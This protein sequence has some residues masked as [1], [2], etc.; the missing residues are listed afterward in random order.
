MRWPFALVSVWLAAGQAMAAEAARDM[1]AYLADGYRIAEKQ[2]EKRTVPG[3]PP[4]ERMKRVLHITTYR[5]ERGAE[6]VICEVTYD[7][8]QDTIATICQ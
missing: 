1:A 7:S 3:K 4:Y 5:F 8:Q 2:E 6:Q